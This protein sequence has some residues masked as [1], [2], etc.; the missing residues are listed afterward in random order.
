VRWARSPLAWVLAGAFV[1]FA[2]G[3]GWGLPGSDPWDND[4]VAPRDFLVA[5]AQTFDKDHFDFAYLHLA[6]VHLVLLAI[7]TLPV[8]LVALVT[9]G[10]TAPDHV[11]RTFI[12][13]RFM[14]PIAW[15][16]R[17]VSVAMALGVVLALAKVGEE[18]R[19]RRAG[20]LVAAACATNA[21]LVYY[22]H[23]TNL[24]VPYLFWGSW[25][26]LA[27]VRTIVHREPRRL[28]AFA[29][30]G[31]LAIGSKD[32]AAGLFLLGAPCTLLAW[33]LSDPWAR[34]R[35]KLV[36]KEAL[37][38]L[39]VAVGVFLVA[40]EVVLN[41][42]GFAARVR[43]LLGPASQDW[44]GYSHDV[45]GKIALLGDI[46]T[47]TTLVYPAIV[48]LAGIAGV[49]VAARAPRETRAAALAPLACALSF[50]VC[51]NFTAGRTEERFILPEMLAL[52]LYAGIA[53][54]FL[55][56]AARGTAARGLARA[57]A[58][59]V[60]GWAAFRAADVDAV[61]LFDPRYDAEAW[62]DAHVGPGDTIE[63][64][65]RN[66]YLPRFPWRARTTRVDPGP[67][68][69][70]SPLP[71]LIERQDAWDDLPSRRPKWI[72]VSDAWAWRFL[73]DVETDLPRGHLVPR[74]RVLEVDAPTCRYFR[75]LLAGELGYRVAHTSAW[76][77][78]FWPDVQIHSSTGS[79]VWILERVD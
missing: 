57:F 29:V 8:S 69:G 5:V 72:S 68:D 26:L 74:A 20:V 42:T 73:K 30:L 23:T 14:T 15:I 12:E 37:V 4:G 19:G 11:V 27:L 7:V 59:L 39:G 41:P 61:L 28:R 65:G 50:V 47:H 21:A 46:A 38:A 71:G 67:T 64:Y 22:A 66:V 25:A 17:G 63:T 9:A 75:A 78:R 10:G 34:E 36:A 1:L 77:S 70:R 35:W 56:A 55:L 2:V 13:M 40:D 53:L 79:A 54:D 49:L 76:S 24:E 43:F 60:L 33:V 31:A 16:A 45:A 18:L 44:T 32:Q 52:G 62:L 51:I 48:G 6:P 3:L 58:A